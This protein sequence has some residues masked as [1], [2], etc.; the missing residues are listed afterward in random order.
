LQVQLTS[1]PR[2]VER[3]NGVV[4]FSLATLQH[5]QNEQWVASSA[6]IWRWFELGFLFFVSEFVVDWTKHAFIAKFNDIQPELYTKFSNAMYKDLTV[7]P[8]ASSSGVQVDRMQIVSRR[9]GFTPLPL[10]CV[11]VRLVYTA[12]PFF[13]WFNPTN[14]DFLQS[15][16]LVVVTALTFLTLTSLKLLVCIILLGRACINRMELPPQGEEEDNDLERFNFAR[17]WHIVF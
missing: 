14:G 11:F 13:S 17:H 3:F 5:L 10:A 7:N 15:L 2:Q 16:L 12:F 4:F 8:S 9:I 6:W 1:N